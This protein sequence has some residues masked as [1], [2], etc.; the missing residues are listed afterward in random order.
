MLVHLLCE[1][2]KSPLSSEIIHG[3]ASFSFKVT[4]LSFINLTSVA[5][6]YSCMRRLLSSLNIL[7]CVVVIVIIVRLPL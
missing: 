6:P 5:R 4:N 7:C 3:L 2:G 1:Y